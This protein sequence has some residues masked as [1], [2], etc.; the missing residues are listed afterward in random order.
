MIYKATIYKIISKNTNRI[1]V[2]HTLETLEDRLKWHKN[3]G[4]RTSSYIILEFGDYEIIK[5]CIVEANDMKYIYFEE[6]H[7]I[8]LN[9]NITVN[10]RRAYCSEAYKINYYAKQQKEYYQ[11]NKDSISKREKE[12]Y[13]NNKNS[14]VKR[15]KEFYQ[16]NKNSINKQNNE[17]NEK[18]KHHLKQVRRYN[19]F[20]L[21]F[22]I[23]VL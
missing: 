14:I 2:G 1:Y 4:N 9:E 20:L 10:K 16:N 15:K 21:G 13:Q 6:Q 3:D 18:N 8:D 12:Y 5:L 7:Y 23:D 17:Y 11:N 22:L 19:K